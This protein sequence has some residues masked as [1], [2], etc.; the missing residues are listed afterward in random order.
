MKNYV[1]PELKIETVAFCDV[2]TTSSATAF[3]GRSQDEYVG[4]RTHINSI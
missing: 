2:L 4:D 1:T 3:A